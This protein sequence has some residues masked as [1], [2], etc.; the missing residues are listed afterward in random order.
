MFSIENNNIYRD[1]VKLDFKEIFTLY[2]N[3]N[4]D[5]FI[6]F[7]DHNKIKLNKYPVIIQVKIYTDKNELKL[8][9][10]YNQIPISIDIKTENTFISDST[11]NVIDPEYLILLNKI[12]GDLNII[13]NKITFY[14]YLKLLL[15][16]ELK[17]LNEVDVNFSK[18]FLTKIDFEALSNLTI[19][20]SDY[21][22]L[23][24]NWMY[25]MYKQNIGVILADEMGLGKTA[26]YISLFSKI[27]ENNDKKGI[28]FT[29]SSNLENVFREFQ[30][31]TKNLSFMIYAGPDRNPSPKLFKNHDIIISS[32]DTLL[33]DALFLKQF[34][35]DIVI[36]DESQFIKNRDA[37]RS[38]AI[39]QLNSRFNLAISGTPYENNLE[40]LWSIFEFIMPDWL[41]DISSF[42]N[43]YEN[44]EISAS[45]LNPIIKPLILQ[46]KITEVDKELPEKTV[47]NQYLDFTEEMFDKYKS[48]KGKSFSIANITN[49]KIFCNSP[50]LIPEFRQDN[51]LDTP[52]INFLIEKLEE[53]KSIKS[54]A[55]VF[56]NYI[57]LID[58]LKV[59]IQ[60]KLSIYCNKIDGSI[61]Q[62]DRQ[63]I[64]DEFSDLENSA[65]LLLNPKAAAVGLNITSANYVFLF[66]PE[67]NPSIE[68][69]AIAR[70][71]R[72]GQKN[73]VFAYRMIYKKS[74][75][76]YM[77]EKSNFKKAVRDIVMPG[78]ME[79]DNEVYISDNFFDYYNNDY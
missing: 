35:W 69:Q 57:H 43:Q 46:R 5:E 24:V 6:S 51:I 39:K 42:K 78:H 7:I 32:Y 68:E 21:Q 4:N 64:I 61:P 65:V 27:N 34:N 33:V 26:Q 72:R 25:S 14:Q 28:I 49:L 76:E 10:V 71:F 13:D 47:I 15:N 63:T 36:S 77:L 79:K 8:S 38:K 66:S 18:S 40:D 45:D 62:S 41:G 9:F 58:E 1:G 56:I 16:K 74:I 67:W 59:I 12:F 44:N 60:E 22:K 53:L 37:K 54:K 73:K 23:G 50:N 75:E 20:L 52:K 70:A 31:F 30:K 17:I 2:F 11:W 55:I 29:N 48:I 19:K 3:E